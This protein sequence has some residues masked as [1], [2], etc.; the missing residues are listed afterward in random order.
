MFLSQIHSKHR[1]IKYLQIKMKQNFYLSIQKDLVNRWT[2]MVLLNIVYSKIFLWK[3][4]KAPANKTGI[5]V[6]IFILIFLGNGLYYDVRTGSYPAVSNPYWKN[7][8]IHV[9]MNGRIYSNYRLSLKYST[10]FQFLFDGRFVS[11]AFVLCIWE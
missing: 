7:T 1:K 9:L 4:T 3:N 11:N 10:I 6:M 2:D 5:N 8:F